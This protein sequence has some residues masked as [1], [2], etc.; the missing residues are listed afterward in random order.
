MEK[1]KVIKNRKQYDTYCKKAHELLE[2][3][4]K[5]KAV[6]D[7]I[8]LLTL[9]IRDY[10]E[11]HRKEGELDPIDFLKGMM[12][13]NGMVQRDLAELFGTRP[14]EASDLLNR[15]KGLSKRQIK[16]LAQRFRMGEDAFSGSYRLD[17]ELS[18]KIPNAHVASG[19]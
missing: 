8:E 3:P 16:L 17:Y 7:E 9:L 4:E 11:R 1:Y 5:T 12:E 19:E 10:D 13:A 15:R 6:E 14:A 18:P 2:L